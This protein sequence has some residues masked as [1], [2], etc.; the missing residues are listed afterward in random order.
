M[1]GIEGVQD[2]QTPGANLGHREGSPEAIRQGPPP[3]VLHREEHPIAVLH[4]VEHAHHVGVGH[5]PGEPHFSLGHF[6]PAARVGDDLHGDLFRGDLV[7]G[8]VD[9]G[10]AASSEDPNHLVASGDLLA[11]LVVAVGEGR[12]LGVG[13]GLHG[14]K[15]ARSSPY[16]SIHR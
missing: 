16:F 11:G 5:A 14:L 3:R 8:A 4:D 10:R 2:A 15:L 7:E 12:L 13:D 1:G 9:G 6:G